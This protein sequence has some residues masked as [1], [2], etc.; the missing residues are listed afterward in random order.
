MAGSYHRSTTRGRTPT[1]AATSL[2]RSNWLAGAVG[3]PQ[4]V[5]GSTSQHV[6]KERMIDTPGPGNYNHVRIETSWLP[7]MT[8]CCCCRP[9]VSHGQCH[10]LSTRSHWRRGCAVKLGMWQYRTY[11]PPEYV[12]R[13]IIIQSYRCLIYLILWK[14][15]LCFMN[16][17]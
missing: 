13:L 3:G 10:N 7:S 12:A 16:E 9:Q 1:P 15:E 8:C 4:A 17:L 6:T 2:D 11:V 5:T 14:C